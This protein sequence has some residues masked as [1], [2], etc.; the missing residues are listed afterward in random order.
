MFAL[1]RLGSARLGPPG[2]ARGGGGLGAVKRAS[3][4]VFSPARFFRCKAT[5]CEPDEHP[6]IT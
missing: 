1:P 6:S 3:A 5:T 2:A 4:I